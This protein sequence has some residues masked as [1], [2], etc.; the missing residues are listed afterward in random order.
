ML[1][2]CY[3]SVCVDNKSFEEKMISLLLICLAAFCNAVMDKLA[4]HFERSCFND[5]DPKFWN[6]NVSWKYAKFIPFTKY[7]VDAWHLFKSAMIVLI[8]LAIIFYSPMINIWID[9]LIFG[10]LW[11]TVFNIYFNKAL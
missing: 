7:R 3:D 4:W 1:I 9:F 6:P 2:Y 10:I 5:Y 8:C 11:N